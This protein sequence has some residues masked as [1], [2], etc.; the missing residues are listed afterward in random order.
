MQE[1]SE[2]LSP[3]LQNCWRGSLTDAAYATF[4]SS[5]IN[6]CCSS[7]RLAMF[8]LGELRPEH[9]IQKEIE[10][11]KSSLKCKLWKHYKLSEGSE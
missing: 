7:K 6:L 11:L 2:E 9:G 5:E 10:L 4:N 8:Q 1:I 3:A